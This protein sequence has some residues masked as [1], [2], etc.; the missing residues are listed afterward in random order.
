M[1]LDIIEASLLSA[2][3]RQA[4]EALTAA[5]YPP[6]PRPEGTTSQPEWARPQW[7]IMI[8]DE[9]QQLVSHVGVLTRLGFCE[10][11]EILIGGIGGVKTHPLER[12]KG[13]AG[14]GVRRAT[15]Y[16]QQEMGVDMTLLFC[17]RN[18][19]SYYQRLGFIA[20]DGDTFVRQRGVKTLFPHNEVMVKPAGK[21]L[22]QCA[23]LD[24]CG[25]PW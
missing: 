22:P 19:L 7:S 21:M 8:R 6:K 5:V 15:S 25:L 3:D 16:L 24:L 11:E 23:E 20:R 12:G 2:E 1:R 4:L 17:G 9:N 13:Y 18:M 10:G 14:A